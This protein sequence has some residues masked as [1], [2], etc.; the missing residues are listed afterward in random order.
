M[1]TAARA[2][3]VSAGPAGSLRARLVPACL[4]PLG[5]TA[6]TNTL[7]I[8]VDF[9]GALTAPCAVTVETE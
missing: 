2:G 9:D 3:Y 4:A 7:R 5:A 8:T 6:A 1:P